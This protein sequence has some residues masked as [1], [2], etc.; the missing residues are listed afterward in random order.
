MSSNVCDIYKGR[1]GREFF[2]VCVCD[3]GV[4]YASLDVVMLR[5]ISMCSIII[6]LLF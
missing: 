4:F 3:D 2:V 1:N 5:Y 6:V